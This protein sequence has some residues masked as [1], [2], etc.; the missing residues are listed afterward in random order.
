MPKIA[1]VLARRIIK[2]VRDKGSYT[3]SANMS[4]DLPRELAAE[5]KVNAL[6]RRGGG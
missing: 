2:T 6:V 5:E 3:G 1:P 4:F